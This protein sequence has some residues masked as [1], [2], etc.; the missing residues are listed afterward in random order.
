MDAY[1]QKLIRL[2]A[3]NE[4]LKHEVQKP[5]WEFEFVWIWRAV[6]TIA[7]VYIVYYLRSYSRK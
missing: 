3:K 5:F 1:E 2:L 6:I 4:I 7:V